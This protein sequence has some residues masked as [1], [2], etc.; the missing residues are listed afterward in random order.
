MF[1][2]PMG[3][4]PSVELQHGCVRYKMH[5]VFDRPWQGDLNFTYDFT[6]IKPLDFNMDPQLRMPAQQEEV[7][8]FCCCFCASKPVMLSASIPQSGFV[9]GQPVTIKVSVNN[10]TNTEINH[11][12]IYV[13][14]QITYN[15]Q[16]P[17]HKSKYEEVQLHRINHGSVIKNCQKEYMIDLTIPFTTSSTG[18]TQSLVTVIDIAYK[19]IVKAQV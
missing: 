13:V 6:V 16:T 17:Y 19:L 7:K 12:E 4:P 2:V 9:V 10:P 11:I 18:N 1:S 3:A 5:V 15:S 14:K 8:T